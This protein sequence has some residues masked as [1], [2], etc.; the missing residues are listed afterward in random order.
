MQAWPLCPRALRQPYPTSRMWRHVQVA[1]SS[2]GVALKHAHVEARASGDFGHGRSPE[3]SRIPPAPT[4]G[5]SPQT[6]RCCFDDI[7]KLQQCIRGHFVHE[8][9]DS[10]TKHSCAIYMDFSS[11]RGITLRARGL[12]DEAIFHEVHHRR[13]RASST[14]ASS[15]IQ[16][17]LVA[18]LQA[19]GLC[20]PPKCATTQPHSS[21][22]HQDERTL[23][24]VLLCQHHVREVIN[25]PAQGDAE[26]SSEFGLEGQELT[27][28]CRCI[29]NCVCESCQVRGSRFCRSAQCCA[30][31]T[32]RGRCGM[33]NFHP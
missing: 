8:Q 10:T 27:N 14:S 1:I 32:F 24:A 26:R 13:S 25:N 33:K 30:C 28:A 19:A 16:N 4:S 12:H 22:I 9:L 31:S 2:M 17:D 20:T 11:F 5:R 23:L 7:Y 15:V 29:W 6:S 18:I 21:A 3:P